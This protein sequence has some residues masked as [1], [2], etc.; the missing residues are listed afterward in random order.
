VFGHVVKNRFWLWKALETYG[1][2]IYFILKQN[3]FEFE[4]PRPS[5]LDI[6]DDPPA[7]FILA[8]VGTFALVYSLWDINLSYYKPVMT[9]LL[10]FAWLFFMI[11]FGI[12]DFEIQRFI[13]FESMYSFFVLAS[14]V[15][16]IVIG[17]D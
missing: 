3:A 17:D 1:L 14:T 4:P 13:S 15:G 5:L 7:I 16:E 9:G 2:G 11:A 10:T 12:H 8:V 6:F